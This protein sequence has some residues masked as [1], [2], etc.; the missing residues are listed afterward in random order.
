MRG[1]GGLCG[2]QVEDGDFGGGAEAEGDADDAQSAGDVHSAGVSRVV[3][4]SLLVEL[5]AF[6]ELAGLHERAGEDREVDLPAVRVSGQGEAGEVAQDAIVD[7][8]VC[9]G[10]DGLG[11][12]DVA[13]RGIRV[14]VASEAVVDAGDPEAGF[15]L[16]IAVGEH[17]HF[18]LG[19]RPGDGGASALA[20]AVVVVVAQAGVTSE[21]GAQMG[22][23]C[24]AGLGVVGAVGDEV[25]GQEHD[26][27]LEGVGALDHVR[28]EP[29]RDAP[30]AVQVGELHQ[31]DGLLEAAQGDCV[32]GCGD[33]LAFADGGAE[34]V[35]P[36]ECQC[37]GDEL[38]A[39][40]GWAVCCVVGCVRV[41]S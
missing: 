1:A 9:H 19:E 38:A 40:D 34:E 7:G 24:G 23:L 29:F 30:G 4:P 16:D 3:E 13:E 5:D 10:D 36:E 14:G 18:G 8:V 21:G 35:G 27:G 37:A 25:A 32:E 22:E 39:R 11:G 41:H 2:D 20:A 26:V 33:A 6:A 28:D 31:A 17:A 12:G 15:Q